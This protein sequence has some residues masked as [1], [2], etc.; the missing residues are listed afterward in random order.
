[1]GGLCI[2]C[3]NECCQ[4]H[5][6]SSPGEVSHVLHC[7]P[8]LSIEKSIPD[9]SR[10][11]TGQFEGQEG[12]ALIFYFHHLSDPYLWDMI[13]YML[14]SFNTC[15]AQCCSIRFHLPHGFF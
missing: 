4:R 14:N 2:N 5:L 10:I 15:P 9:A 8:K 3:N 6:T 13:S 12:I 11:Q 7:C 1:M